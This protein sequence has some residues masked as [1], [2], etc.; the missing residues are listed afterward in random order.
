M[1]KTYQTQCS[2]AEEVALRRHEKKHGKNCRVIKKGDYPNCTNSQ[3]ENS[4]KLLLGAVVM[5]GIIIAGLGVL[6]FFSRI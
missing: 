4:E 5:V 2:E 3:Y 1:K 6:K